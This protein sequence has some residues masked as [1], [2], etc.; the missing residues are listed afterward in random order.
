MRSKPV[1]M[2]PPPPSLYRQL[3]PLGSSPVLVPVLT[4]F[5]D[6]LLCR[7]TVIQ[8]NPFLPKLLLVTVFHHSNSD[9]DQDNCPGGT[10]EAYL[11]EA[12]PESLHSTQRIAFPQPH[13]QS[14][15]VTLPS[16]C[17]PVTSLGSH[18]AMSSYIHT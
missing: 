5:N 11:K 3:L 12:M 14:S 6:G 13:I 18:E 1:S 2:V 8:I 4:S 16:L 15:Q 10:N 17:T 9:P 7:R